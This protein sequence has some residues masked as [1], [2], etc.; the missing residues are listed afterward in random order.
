MKLFIAAMGVL[1]CSVSQAGNMDD[2]PSVHVRYDDLNLHNLHGAQVL[3]WRIES[4]A[5][6]VCRSYESAQLDLKVKYNSCVGTAIANAVRAVNNRTVL[7]LYVERR[8]NHG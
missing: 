8:G 1:V 2:P 5:E 6:T 3:L 4:A 7:A